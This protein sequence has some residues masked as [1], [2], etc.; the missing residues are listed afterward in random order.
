MFLFLETQFCDGKTKTIQQIELLSKAQPFVTSL[1]KA[2][3]NMRIEPYTN[4]KH[5]MGIFDDGL[6][7]E[8]KIQSIV[9]LRG[10]LRHHSLRSPHRWNPNQQMEYE[11]PAR[12][13]SNVVAD[14]VIKETID[15]IY[16]PEALK[17]F[18]D[19]SVSSGFETKI[20]VLTRRL[21]NLKSLVLNMSFPTTVISSKFCLT[22]ARQALE[23]C[24][25]DGQIVDTTRFDATHMR[26]KLELFEA[27]LD[28]WAY[29]ATR[30]IKLDTLS[31]IIKCKFEHYQ[32]GVVIS[33]EFSFPI[34]VNEINIES[35]WNLLKYC[36]EWIETKDPTTRIMT[37]KLLLEGSVRPILTYRVGAQVKN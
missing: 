2:I 10:K 37:L 26:N 9:N 12:F 14:T 23:A 3:S 1:Q 21:E 7:L 11:P 18:R 19:L 4:S 29:T 34:K 13:L 17:I 28:L 15:E 30:S 27:T 25:K 6:S 33:H 35:A 20:Q 32:A 16:A 24:T 36:F 31:E 22:A 5:L 8:K